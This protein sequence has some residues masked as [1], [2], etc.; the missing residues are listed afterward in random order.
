MTKEEQ[1]VTFTSFILVTEI[2]PKPPAL[3]LKYLKHVSYCP[4]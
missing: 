2:L 4:N 3:E 1:K